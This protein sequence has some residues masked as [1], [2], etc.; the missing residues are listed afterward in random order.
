VTRKKKK[1]K[2]NHTPGSKFPQR[3]DKRNMR[4]GGRGKGEVINAEKQMIDPLAGM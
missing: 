1:K 2:K 4:G 3:V